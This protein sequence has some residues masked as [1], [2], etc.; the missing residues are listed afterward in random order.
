[1]G[2]GAAKQEHAIKNGEKKRMRRKMRYLLTTRI[3]MFPHGLQ[4]YDE[5]LPLRYILI[6]LN[7]RVEVC[8]VTGEG[9]GDSYQRVQYPIY[10]SWDR[11]LLPCYHEVIHLKTLAVRTFTFF[12]S[13]F[14]FPV[15]VSFYGVFLSSPLMGFICL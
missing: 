14:P 13:S 9:L 1:M 15:F 5:L 3:F 2:I 7:A 10:C 12:P 4:S 6:N 11:Y 8:G